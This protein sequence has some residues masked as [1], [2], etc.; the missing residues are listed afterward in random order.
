MARVPAGTPRDV[1]ERC[2]DCGYTSPPSTPRDAAFRLRR[3]KC[4]AYR[5]NRSTDTSVRDV[6]RTCPDCEFVSKPS[7]EARAAAALR[8]HS[9][10]A[11]QPARPAGRPKLAPG[12]VGECTH[13]PEHPHGARRYRA[14][15]CKCATCRKGAA[16]ERKKTRRDVAYGRGSMVDA[17]P[18]RRHLADL[19]ASR[20][21]DTKIAAIT[22]LS[23]KAIGDI[24]GSTTKPGVQRVQRE[25]A[26]AILAVT[27]NIAEP[28]LGVPSLATARRLQALVWEGWTVRAIGLRLGVVPQYVSQL[29]HQAKPTVT[30]RTDARVAAL[31]RELGHRSPP[32]LT[33]A[34][35]RAADLAAAMARR[36]GWAPLAA[37]DDITN[38]LERP[39][40]VVRQQAA[41]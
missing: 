8:S 14:D 38:P 15:G 27:L 17:A 29:L 21:S 20:V 7:T 25:T 28:D 19:R 26:D 6:V 18:V 23:T 9:C 4:G 2:S 1:V 33:P 10:A 39:K 16:A 31:A 22:G 40:G 35:R 3:H 13:T 11:H 37:W 34:Q 32:R 5:Q 41:A 12:E 36:N 30:P 24:R